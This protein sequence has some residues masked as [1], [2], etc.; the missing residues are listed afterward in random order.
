MCFCGQER[1]KKLYTSMTSLYYYLPAFFAHWWTYHSRCFVCSNEDIRRQTG[2]HTTAP[3]Q[4]R[5]GFNRV[6]MSLNL[7]MYFQSHLPHQRT[8][9]SRWSTPLPAPCDGHLLN[10]SSMVV[11][12]EVSGYVYF[13]NLGWMHCI[14]YLILSMHTYSVMRVTWVGQKSIRWLFWDVFQKEKSE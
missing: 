13:I 8:W 14:N 9:Y 5:G 11:S 7:I 12:S 2:V 1:K 3:K 4:W 10:C 6:L